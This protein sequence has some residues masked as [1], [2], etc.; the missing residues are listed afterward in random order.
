MPEDSTFERALLAHSRKG[1]RDLAGVRPPV[2]VT[3]VLVTVTVK[4][5]LSYC[6]TGTNYNDRQ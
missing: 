1:P 6:C 5:S 4:L 2:T 3:V